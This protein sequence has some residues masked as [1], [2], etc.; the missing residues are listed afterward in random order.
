MG[1]T[2]TGDGVIGNVFN[3]LIAGVGNH[4][5]TYNITN[6]S[7]CNS[8]DQ[9]IIVV[10]ATPNATI[11]PINN[12]CMNNIKIPLIVHDTGGVWRGDGVIGNNFNP[13]I[14]GVGTHIIK[15]KIVNANCSDSDQISVTV[16]PIPNATITPVN[17]LCTDDPKVTL[18]AVDIGG[19]WTG[20]GITGNIFD[21]AI[22]GVGN[23][24]IRYN[25]T[26][27]S[28]CQ[29][30]DHIV[31]KVLAS[32]NA[33]IVPVD[34][35]CVN[36]PPVTL[37]VVDNSGIWS[38]AATNNIFDPSKI[39]VGN[40]IVKYRVTNANGCSDSDQIVVTIMPIPIVKIGHVGTV[41]IGDPPFVLNAIPTGGTFSGIAVTGNMFDPNAAGLGVHVVG[42]QSAIDK[43]GCSASDTIH[44]KVIMPLLPTANFQP[45][46]TGCAPLTV[47]FRNYSNNGTTCLWDFGDG[48]LSTET[49]PTH[50]YYTVGNY[51]VKLIETNITGESIF[52]GSVIVYQNPIAIFTI[53]P[54]EITNN[55][56]IV[57]FT[58]YS[59]YNTTNLW[60][61]G[62]EIIS[63][64]ESPWHKYLAE[65]TYTVT[66]IISSSE[67]CIDSTKL[68]TPIK[69]R[70]IVGKIVFPNA[71]RWNQSGQTG[72]YWTEEGVVDDYIFRPHFENVLEY[73]LQI[74][75][76]WGVLIYES[77]NLYKGWDG[78][79]ANGSLAI[80]GVYIWKATGRFTD[81]RYFD[82]VGDVTFLH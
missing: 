13:L 71:F 41:F 21:P 32:P 26:N 54:P 65:G 82:I 81:G 61:F 46:T 38:G 72:G 33:T 52:N 31:I 48:V 7:G 64:E 69:V 75:N 42:Y 34:T 23:H 25:V 20:D 4:I 68:T 8:F 9:I 12:L 5:I 15:Y 70:F 44:I 29:D 74:F 2:W 49:N 66:L 35:L 37:T 73:H 6:S 76:R 53:Y 43:F 22:A 59:Q 1:G 17:S 30:S 39:G 45:D 19:T 63:I 80:Q 3:P 58:N 56:Q 11:T 62:D 55:S 79:F 40:H 78:Y 27:S 16:F 67:G 57:V 51:I 18:T 36:H 10:Q 28:G 77:H 50:T 24:I 60:D 14:A 47:K